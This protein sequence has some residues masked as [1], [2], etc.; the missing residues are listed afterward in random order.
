LTIKTLGVVVV[1]ASAIGLSVGSATPAKAACLSPDCKTVTYQGADYDVSKL[2]GTFNSLQ[3]T[4]TQ[5]PWWNS[6]SAASA[7][8]G[9]VGGDLGFPNTGG[10]YSLGPFFAFANPDNGGLFAYGTVD[11]SPPQV[12]G[13][14]GSPASLPYTYA[15]ATP[16]VPVPTPALLPGLVGMGVAALR[17][18]KA[19]RA[20][21][22]V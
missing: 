3:S 10:N 5:Q 20:E 7:F 22:E 15:V 4:L 9:L 1:G 13:P 21:A 19:D 2:T 16:S 6:S 18:H 17:K 14:F 11:N 12:F 8:A